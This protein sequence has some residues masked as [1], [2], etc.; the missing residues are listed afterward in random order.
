MEQQ[1]QQR[2]LNIRVRYDEAIKGITEYNRK[3][4]ELKVRELTLR[5][6]LKQGAI[7][8]KEYAQEMEATG[9]VVTQYKD[10]VRV[11]R[12]ELQNNLKQEQ[13]QVG[14]L[15][16]LRAELSNA[17][18]MYDEMSRAER[19][20]AKGKELRDHIKEITKELKGAEEETDR[21][22]RNVGNYKQSI[23]EALGGNN[24]FAT[25]LLNMASAEGGVSSMFQ[26][27]VTGARAFGAALLSL[28]TNPVFLALAGIVGAGLAFKWFYDYNVGIME[29]TRLTKEFTGY[30]GDRLES[31]RNSI[32]ATADTFGKDYKETLQTVDALMSQYHISAEE[33]LQV[34]NDGF[35]AGAD[36]SG[37]MLA[38]MQ[39]YA[40]TFHN[41]GIEASQMAA[42]LAQTRSGIFSDKGMEAIQTASTKI[43]EMSSK[44]ASSLDAIGIS[45]KKVEEDLKSGAKSTFDVIQEV[46]SKL[47]E[48]PDDSQEVGEAIKYVFGKT[49]A[50]GGQEM[51][52]M[53]D[54]M[55]TSIEEVKKQTGEYGELQEK[56][57]EAQRELNDV[58]SALFDM[59]Q[60]GFEGLIANVKLL[61]TQWM[62][63][64]L[65][66]V[67]DVANYFIDLYN[68][69]MVFRGAVQAIV[70]NFKLMWNAVK[71]AFNLII[72]Q[73]KMAGRS[74]KGFATI[75][76][77]IFTFSLDKVKDG[78]SQLFNSVKQG[79]T[80]QF[81]DVKNWGVGVADTFVDAFNNTL[82]NK[83]I[84]HIEVPVSGGGVEGNGAGGGTGT[85]KGGGN[86][87][88][89]G[90][91]TTTKGNGGKT[92]AAAKE[93][94]EAAKKEREELR[95]AQDLMLK[96]VE[97]TYE[98][99]RQIII[100]SYDRQIEDIKTRLTT[101][102]NLTATARKAMNA[103]I[104]SLEQIK[105]RELEALKRSQLEKD[106][107][108]EQERIKLYLTTVEKGSLEE[109][110]LKAQQLQNELELAIAKAE[111]EY[112][113]EEERQAMIL[114]LR[115]AYNVKLGQ[116]NDEQNNAEEERIRQR[117]ETQILQA[118]DN[119]LE[120]ARLTVEERKALLEA[121]QQQEGES[122]AAFNLRKLKMQEEYNTARK[123]LTDK[124]IEV[125][126]AKFDAIS[127][128][129]GGLSQVAEAFGEDSKDLAKVAKVLALGEIAV[130]TGVALAA[131]I[132]QAQ[133]V[134]FPANIAAIATTVTTILANVAS[135]IK[136]VK[137]A[138]FATG[139]AVTGS[140]TGTSDSIPAM[141]SNGESVMT[142]RATSMFAPALS[143][144]N[145]L[146]GGV[147]IVVS[148]PQQQMGEEFLAVAVAR[149]FAMAPRP[150][151]S[152]EEIS[153]VNNRVEVIDALARLG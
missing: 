144:F 65:R 6:Q 81:N 87:A 129:F 72:D 151:V 45:S 21:F 22:Y 67:I 121:A 49:A 31:V 30:T 127:G 69:A 38:K 100:T 133:S 23:I 64:L 18:K 50:Q 128:F 40:P 97:Q 117:F 126:K 96:L 104:T 56:Q 17:T 3:I 12:K 146:G 123:D 113:N 16:Q 76:E 152:V 1:E 110:N 42:M 91:T 108:F 107:A 24:K 55:S 75:L 101:E 9:A 5:A 53:F 59:S 11:L 80:E 48:L 47:R 7:T 73:V 35:I 27:G 70:V 89:G 61:T 111:K 98:Q 103:Q 44:T 39:Q 77:G 130:N 116:L 52:E 4:D 112:T 141:L 136:T 66:G 105:Q 124:E 43:R 88:G 95:K 142:A 19:N 82:H 120:Q 37:D 54:Q 150:V 92:D 36:L 34:V 118:S 62:T 125:E 58:T 2:I 137:S 106:I 149:G 57:L 28:L 119:E 115:K 46:S 132:K 63:K 78:F 134:P 60:N 32:Q 79:Y 93:A 13:E 83:K 90:G 102:K 86:G 51:L 140:G 147:P 10:N 85:G 145:Q 122:L 68:D 143:A 84:E 139:G 135:A 20:G 148:N 109:Y 94:E 8:Q 14:S 41:A 138:K 74:L 26:A 153:E 71:L 114:A 33:A 15:K 131:G 99:K 25:S 29:A